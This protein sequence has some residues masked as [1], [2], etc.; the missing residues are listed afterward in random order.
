MNKAPRKLPPRTDYLSEEYEKQLNA[1]IEAECKRLHEIR[2]EEEKE[3]QKIIDEQYN[4]DE[5][6]YF[7]DHF[8]MLDISFETGF[9][10]DE[11]KNLL[12]K[13]MPDDEPRKKIL[14][15]N[16][17]SLDFEERLTYPGTA[18]DFVNDIKAGY[19]ENYIKLEDCDDIL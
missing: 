6:A 10:V 5:D 12:I 18:T 7:H 9:T 8:N 2:M 16:M 14:L 13:N 19:F 17:N 11:I 1:E 4:G 3:E 15:D